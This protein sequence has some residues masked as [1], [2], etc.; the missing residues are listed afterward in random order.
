MITL[1][2]HSSKEHI[3]RSL[4]CL[5]LGSWR[6]HYLSSASQEWWPASPGWNSGRWT[7][8]LATGKQPVTNPRV[9]PEAWQAANYRWSGIYRFDD[10]QISASRTN[11]RLIQTIA[12]KAL[13]QFYWRSREGSILRKKKKWRQKSQAQGKCSM[14]LRTGVVAQRTLATKRSIRKTNQKAPL[15]N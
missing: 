12:N 11:F 9:K 10:Y 8:P 7:T 2:Q 15:L 6:K 3:C 4:T 13:E 5:P 14:P 1:S